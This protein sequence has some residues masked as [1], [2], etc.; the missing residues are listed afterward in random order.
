MNPVEVIRRKRDGFALAPEEIE[1]F[2]SGSVKGLIPEYQTT[3]FLMATFFQGM[4]LDETVAL[5]RAMI[6]SGR[7]VSFTDGK[8]K[9]DKHSTGGVGDKVS[10]ILAP[11]VA[12]LGVDVPMVSGRGLGH[13][14]G[15]L[16]KLESIQGFRVRIKI[17]EF[18]SLVARHGLAM[19]GQTDD[20]V[21]ADKLLYALR[22][23][24]ATVECIPLITA[25]I[26][27][28]KVA[29]GISGLIL[30][31][32]VGSG[33]FMKTQKDA[34][35]LAKSLVAVGSK[36]G[37]RIR[38]V[39]TDMSQPLGAAVGHANEVL[40]C[41]DVLRG[42]GPA[43]LRDCTVE[44]AAHMLIL[45][46]KATSISAARAMAKKALQNGSA[47][48]KFAEMCKA[49]GATVDV[50]KNPAALLLSSHVV[51]V[52]AP[53]TGCVSKIDGQALGMLLVRMGGGRQ[54]T[55]DAI[56]HAVG[57]RL[58]AKLG[59]QVDK[60]ESLAKIYYNPEKLAAERI[61]VDELVRQFA[62]AYSLTGQ[63]TRTPE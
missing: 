8:P 10:L 18:T 5:T 3:A 20:F 22:D 16:D 24:T 11:L 2:V 57:F 14:G 38:A 50:V 21:P 48:E 53:K 42:K 59:S 58:E 28:K 30:D 47:L 63:K 27:S 45:G 26:L 32:K 4:S 6:E 12:A 49:Q 41:L 52:P 36:L 29:E 35:R 39:L 54:K 13:T 19:M 37:L 46:E 43:D 23:V 33:A 17:E 60:G 7:R 62:A 1:A 15:T 44:L 40:E 31:I 25:S 56:D 55:S 34:E 61:A 9:I 51:D